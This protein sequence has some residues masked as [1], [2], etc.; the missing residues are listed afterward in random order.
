[1]RERGGGKAKRRGK[2]FA[3]EEKRGKGLSTK[4][5][6]EKGRTEK[7]LG[8]QVNGTEPPCNEASQR[9]VPGV[10]PEKQGC[11]PRYSLE[12]GRRVPTLVV[13]KIKIKKQV[14]QPPSKWAFPI[15]G[16]ASKTHWKYGRAKVFNWVA[17]E[18]ENKQKGRNKIGR[19]GP[20][21]FRDKERRRHTI[22]TA[23]EIIRGGWGGRKRG[24]LHT[25]SHRSP[26]SRKTCL[27]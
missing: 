21:R 16:V 2:K 17:F 19:H 5:R 15:R 27:Q 26:Y 9:M 20:L 8:W 4:F 12:S 13:G 23:T 1:M 3:P 24:Q 25:N 6:K 18:G 7:S 11:P 10:T 14:V 22:K